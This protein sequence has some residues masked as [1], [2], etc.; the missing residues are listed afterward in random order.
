MANFFRVFPTIIYNNTPTLDI[1]RRFIFKQNVFKNHFVYYNYIVK[2][3]EL[4][5]AI[6]DKYYGDETL[7][8]VVY[9]SNEIFD[10]IFDWHMPQN[11]FN[12]FIINKYGSLA[13]AHQTNHSYEIILNEKEELNYR[14]WSEQKTVFVDWDTFNATPEERR[15]EL[16]QYDY[17]YELN[18]RRRSIQL[19]DKAFIPQIIQEYESIFRNGK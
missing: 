5:R 14:D 1:T 15:K 7:D 17:E 2:E 12:D 8:W 13:T 16:S 18:E 4:C 11:V 6:C 19:V 3:G 10:P 9:L